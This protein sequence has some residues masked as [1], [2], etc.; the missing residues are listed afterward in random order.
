MS[1]AL[2]ISQY[3]PDQ[4]G[5]PLTDEHVQ[6]CLA[7]GIDRWMVSTID[8]GIARQ[9]IEVLARHPVLIE[10]FNAYEWRTMREAQAADVQFIGEIRRDLYNLQKHWID[11]EAG[12]RKNVAQNIKDA[13][14]L[15]DSFVGICPTGL[16]TAPGWW[17][18]FMGNTD[19][20]H[21][22]P[23]WFAHWDLDPPWD[24]TL[25]MTVPFGGWTRGEMHQTLPNLF[26]EGVWCD[27]NYYEKATPIPPAHQEL[28]HHLEAAL[29]IARSLR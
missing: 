3:A 7:R 13:H 12:T 23:M 9:Q 8:K 21:T 29:K 16:Y 19:E 18:E 10:T 20:F 4:M 24:D 28:I 26:F 2:D 5:G 27:T 14:W 6:R 25:D 11:L 15:I 17:M 1:Y 22:V